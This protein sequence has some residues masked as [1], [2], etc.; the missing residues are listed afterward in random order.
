MVQEVP[1]CEQ[2]VKFTIGGSITV[3]LVSSFTSLD[4]TASLHTNN[5]IFSVLVKSS[6]VKVESVSVLWNSLYRPKKALCT[7]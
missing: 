3:Q 1:Q 5:K 2:S 7:Y 6:L 4:S